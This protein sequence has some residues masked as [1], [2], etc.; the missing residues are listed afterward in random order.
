MKQRIKTFAIISQDDQILMVKHNDPLDGKIFW[1][2]PGGGMEVTDADIFAC[3]TREAFE[4]TSL[5]VKPG[6]IVYIDEFYDLKRDILSLQLFILID[7]FS[8]TPGLAHTIKE[9]PLNEHI[10]DLRWMNREKLAGELFFPEQ[11]KD[12]LW[13]DLKNNFPTFRYLGRRNSD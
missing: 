12:I 9:G 10:Y 8:G 11:L 5:K 6:R 3:V 4:E 7:E 1:V 2:M 13:D